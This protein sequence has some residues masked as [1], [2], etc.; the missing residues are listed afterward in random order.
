MAIDPLRPDPDF[1]GFWQ[2][3][4]YGTLTT[5]RPDGT[6]H[7][8]PVG[9]TYDPPAGLARVTARA[10]SV[11]VRNVRAAGEA[12]APVAV[13][14]ADGPRWATLEGIATVHTDPAAVAEA[15]RRYEAR[16]GRRARPNPDRVVI[17]IALTRA[18]GN[19]GGARRA[20]PAP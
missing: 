14:Q 9:V 18:M 6:P 7:T 5:L 15:V 20:R 19:V 1:L 13:C 16:Y 8:V 11:K 4:H 2:E 3:H 17:H 10:G 12:G